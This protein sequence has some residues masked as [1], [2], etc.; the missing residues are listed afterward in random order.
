M[1]YSH[2]SALWGQSGDFDFDVSWQAGRVGRAADPRGREVKC[3]N[4]KH[5]CLVS[6]R[7]LEE[8]EVA[9]QTCWE[10]KIP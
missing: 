7:P 4:S 1:T 5:V 2:L 8:N 9:G 10:D 3:L 6:Q